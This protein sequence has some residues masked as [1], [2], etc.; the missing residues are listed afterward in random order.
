MDSKNQEEKKIAGIYIRVST[1]DQAREGFS[2]GEQEEKLRQLCEFKEYQI[3]KV[4]QDAG[5]SAKDMEHR[6]G[7]QQMMDDM[8]NHVKDWG[9]RDEVKN[10]LEQLVD[11]QAFDRKGLIY[12]MGHAVYSLSDPRARVFKS[13]VERLAVA[14][15]REKDFALYSMVENLAP[16][17]IAEKRH[18]YKGVSANVDFY[19]GFVYSM[20]DIP[21]ELYTPIFAIARIVGWSAH[22][23]EELVNMDK[24]IR[25]AYRSIMPEKAYVPL[26]ER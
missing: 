23:M 14:K 4:Y 5:I 10:Y 25:P 22:R 6:P 8:R 2:L 18:I 1:E 7:F 24:I 9:D 19:S 15:G 21:L 13:F 3:F 17:V 26:E 12:G 20:L 16:E 11:K